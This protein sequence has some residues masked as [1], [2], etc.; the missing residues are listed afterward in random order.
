MKYSKDVDDI[1][2]ILMENEDPYFALGYMQ[3]LFGTYVH[4]SGNKDYADS[5]LSDTLKTLK[6]NYG[7]QNV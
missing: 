6:I 4:L 3:S 7:N 2:K 5:Y 1:I